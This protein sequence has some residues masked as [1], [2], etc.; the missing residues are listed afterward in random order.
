MRNEKEKKNVITK[1][2]FT[3]IDQIFFLNLWQY[4]EIV[5]N[6][7]QVGLCIIGGYE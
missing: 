2:Y 5:K 1:F 7:K 4:I 6:W 3:Y